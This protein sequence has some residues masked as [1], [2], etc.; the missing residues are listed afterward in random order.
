MKKLSTDEFI[1]KAKLVHGDKY[2]Y[3]KTCYVSSNE[4]VIVICKKHGEF[5]QKSCVHLME[6]GCEKCSNEKCG[7]RCRSNKNDFIDKASIIHNKYNYEKFVY[8]NNSIKGIISCSLHGDFL[9]NSA[10]HLMGKGCAKC[11]GVS[12]N[13]DDFIKS[14]I[15]I[16]GNTYDYSKFIYITNQT[17]GIIICKI[18]GNFLQGP[19]NHLQG[20]G[21]PKCKMSKGEIK[22][23]NFLTN[24]FIL[25]D[26][27]K[28]FYDCRNPLTNAI[29]KYDFYI[30]SKNLLVEYD[31]EQHFKDISAPNFKRESLSVI[32]YRDNI[33]NEYAKRNNINLLRIPYTEFNNIEGMIM[34]KLL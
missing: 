15:K 14:A 18:H 12:K 27:N 34:E 29:L 5:L 23:K 22:I 26:Y 4:K 9:Q 33:K 17:R 31:G 7:N 20:S 21:C 1:A 25:Y 13:R 32:C 2:D 16:H 3:S 30:P 11:A 28:V 10:N 8:I 6:C 19:S 24:N